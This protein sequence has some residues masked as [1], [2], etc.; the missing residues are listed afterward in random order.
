MLRH[1]SFMTHAAPAREGFSRRPRKTL[2]FSSSS[3]PNRSRS[4]LRLLGQLVFGYVGRVQVAE[5]GPVTG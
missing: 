5:Q 4:G 2:A 3:S 1:V